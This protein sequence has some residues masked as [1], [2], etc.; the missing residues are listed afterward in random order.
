MKKYVIDNFAALC[1]VC[2][3]LSHCYG[4]TAK[5]TINMSR[6][7]KYEKYESYD[8]LVDGRVSDELREHRRHKKHRE[9]QIESSC[10]HK[11]V[12]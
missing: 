12:Q 11:C 2:Y 6:R 9:L 1:G 7:H 10:E 3:L 5:S 4:V 8:A